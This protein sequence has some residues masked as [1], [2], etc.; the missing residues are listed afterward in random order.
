[1]KRRWIGRKLK[2]VVVL[3]LVFVLSL[4]VLTPSASADWRATPSVNPF[5]DVLPHNWHHDNVSWAW[6]N[7]ITT[8]TSP[9]TFGPDNNVTRAQF[10]TFIH[11][12]AGTP[13]ASPSA[14]ADSDR[15]PGWAA[16]AVCWASSTGVTTGFLNDNTYRPSIDI[17]REQIAAM[18]Y[19]YAEHIGADTTAPEDALSTFPDRRQVSGWA[20]TAMRWAV[21]YRIITGINGNLAP[22]NNATR[23]QTVTMLYRFV[24]NLNVPAP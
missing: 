8:G 19:R 17:T 18:L 23:A 9:S 5:T 22:Q 21:H 6:V 24:E 1:M 20:T 12:V 14:F 2:R 15:I 16:S 11:R 4:G 10:A 13:P 3:T 7:G